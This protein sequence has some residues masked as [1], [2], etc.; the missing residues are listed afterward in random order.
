MLQEIR[1]FMIIDT[2]VVKAPTDKFGVPDLDPVSRRVS[3]AAQLDTY[4]HPY[5]D[6]RLLV[7]STLQLSPC[8][9]KL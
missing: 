6:N 5:E 1:D 8:C 2:V 9:I 3:Q 7:S 4:L